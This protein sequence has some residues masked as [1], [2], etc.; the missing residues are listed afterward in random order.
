MELSALYALVMGSIAGFLAGT[1]AGKLGAR[2]V[3]HSII[4]EVTD[5]LEKISW[6][7]DRIRKRTKINGEAADAP[8]VEL[9][10]PRS[11]ADIGRLLEAR[12][13]EN[14]GG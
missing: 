13:R 12:R 9:T 5:M 7:Y 2:A 6:L 4:L 1:V 11:N 14:R 8:A 10:R 3:H